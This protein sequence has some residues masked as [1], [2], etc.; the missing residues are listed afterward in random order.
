MVQPPEERHHYEL[1]PPDVPVKAFF[2]PDCK[3]KDLAELPGHHSFRDHHEAI[4]ATLIE[5]ESVLTELFG[6]P[7]RLDGYVRM[8]ASTNSKGSAFGG[9]SGGVFELA[10][11]GPLGKVYPE[12]TPV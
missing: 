7:Q 3:A 12:P 1:I 6:G 5:L 4:H 2:D 10:P 11:P 9:T 8:D